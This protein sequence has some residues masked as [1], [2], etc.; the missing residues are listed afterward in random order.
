MNLMAR[1]QGFMDG[2]LERLSGSL[3]EKYGVSR[4]E[5]AGSVGA[6]LQ[7]TYG[8]AMRLAEAISSKKVPVIVFIG[9]EGCNICQRSMPPLERFLQEH[10]DLELVKLDYSEPAALLYHMILHTDKGML[11]LIAMVSEGCISMVFTGEA[12]ATEVYQRHY[13]SLRSEC[14][15]NVYAH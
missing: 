3:A 14:S 6:F 10:R 4:D 15:Q 8:P 12:V 1:V 2:E 13:S 7:E 5:V 9:R 11:P